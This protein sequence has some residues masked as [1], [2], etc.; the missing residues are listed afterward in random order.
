MPKQEEVDPALLR[1]CIDTIKFLDEFPAF[2]AI[3]RD[4]SEYVT[5]FLAF[6]EKNPD[7]REALHRLCRRSL[8]INGLLP[9][10]PFKFTGR[11]KKPP[12]AMLKEKM[13]KELGFD[14]EQVIA[15]LN[16]SYDSR[17]MF[18]ITKILDT[19]IQ[20]FK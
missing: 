20:R 5:D 15:C 19:P 10:V 7:V 18:I 9:K 8:Q 17:E 3:D 16:R 12:A 14:V 6:L 11:N 13:P 1:S 4:S 2:V